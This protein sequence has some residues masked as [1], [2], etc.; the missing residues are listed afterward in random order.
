[1]NEKLKAYSSTITAVFSACVVMYGV[2]KFVNQGNES[3]VSTKG[4][5]KEMK[6][7]KKELRETAYPRL[8]SIE[9]VSIRTENNVQIVGTK[10]DRLVNKFTLHLSKDSSVTKEELREIINELNEKKN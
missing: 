1:M 9:Q 7:F 4:L 3:A 6:E 10:V 2:F 8:D 5:E